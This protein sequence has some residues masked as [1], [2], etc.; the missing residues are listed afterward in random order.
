MHCRATSQE[1]WEN[2]PCCPLNF[3]C[4]KKRQT[5]S[6]RIYYGVYWLEQ[7]SKQ[8]FLRIS[9]K[10][11]IRK[12]ENHTPV[13][14]IGLKE[15]TWELKSTNPTKPKISSVM[16]RRQNWRHLYL[17]NIVF[18]NVGKYC[19]LNLWDSLREKCP[20]SK[21]FWSVFSRIQSECGKMRT[22]ITPNTD[23]FYAVI[24]CLGVGLFPTLYPFSFTLVSSWFVL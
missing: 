19:I 5:L 8:Y 6:F 4:L 20:Y 7:D 23:T 3:Q 15:S 24:I 14:L 17:V 1:V 13:I 2:F 9:T 16:Q 21:L 11:I 22:K 12:S 18:L 10:S